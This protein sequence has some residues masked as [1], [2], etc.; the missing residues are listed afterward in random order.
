MP[1][2][3]YR[4]S[5]DIRKRRNMPYVS[6]TRRRT[7]CVPDADIIPKNRGDICSQ[8]RHTVPPR[9][10]GFITSSGEMGRAQKNRSH[11][12]RTAHISE[13]GELAPTV[14]RGRIQPWFA[15]SSLD[16]DKWM[17]TSSKGARH[18]VVTPGAM[19]SVE[20]RCLSALWPIWHV[21]R[22]PPDS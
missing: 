21:G 1:Q 2:A 17:R 5:R 4:A 8:I 19:P 9:G 15:Q 13:L 10:V 22:G 11:N 3:R 7:G 18:S 14:I 12:E 20:I 6:V 16:P